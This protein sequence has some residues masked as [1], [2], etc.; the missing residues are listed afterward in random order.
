MSPEQ[1]RYE[2][3]DLLRTMPSPQEFVQTGNLALVEW[4]GRAKAVLAA[5]DGSRAIKFDTFYHRTRMHSPG[6][7][8]AG[9][10][11]I[12]SLLHEARH[13][14]RLASAAPTAVAIPSNSPF[15]YFD[16]LRK[17]VSTATTDVF[18]VDPYLD[19]D[20]VS[21][22]LPSVAKGATVR[23]LAQKGV[24]QLVPAVAMFTKQHGTV[25]QVRSASTKMHDRFV[26]IDGKAG[27]QSGASFKDGGAHSPTTLTEMVDVFDAVLSTYE[28]MWSKAKPEN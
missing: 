27:Y 11:D 17:I 28:T 8:A 7:V 9:Y 4:V 24:A 19:P 18:F 14:L 22:Y 5:W 15:E 1:L 25:I 2:I 21:S 13:S 10:A 20:F 12:V 26:F 23:L 3:E 16:E 6:T